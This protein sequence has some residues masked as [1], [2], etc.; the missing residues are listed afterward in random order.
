MQDIKQDL[1]DPFN[2]RRAYRRAGI[3]NPSD[4]SSIALAVDPQTGM[5]YVAFTIAY[6]ELPEG[7]SLAQ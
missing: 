6:S 5:L 7:Y 1:Q 4:Y 3:K 2:F